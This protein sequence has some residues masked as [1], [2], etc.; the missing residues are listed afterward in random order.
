MKAKAIAVEQNI[1]RVGLWPLLALLVL[2]AS[3]GCATTARPGEGGGRGP[4]DVGLSQD[5]PPTGVTE[6]ITVDLS[7]ID[8]DP[9][10]RASD[11]LCRDLR[12]PLLQ[13][14]EA[15]DPAQEAKT[16]GLKVRE[17]RVQ[18]TLILTDKDSAFLRALAVDVGKQAGNQV[19]AYVPISQLCEL[20][21]DKRIQAIYPASQ[22]ETQ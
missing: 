1:Y 2:I 11:K 13:V 12:S 16:L 20:A 19:Q 9:R 22:A 18:V 8:L 15:A 3:T 5:A 7:T 17:D 14:V 10:I 6:I 4:G 21:A